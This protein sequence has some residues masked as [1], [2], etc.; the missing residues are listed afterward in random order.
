MMMHSRPVTHFEAASVFVGVHRFLIK[1]KQRRK[2]NGESTIVQS[3]WIK[4]DEDFT[5]YDYL[6]YYDEYGSGRG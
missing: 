1:K 5:G 2:C 4:V 3:I 6:P